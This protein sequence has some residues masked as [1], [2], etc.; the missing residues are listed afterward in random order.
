MDNMAKSKKKTPVST[1]CCCK[2]QKRGKQFSH[3]KFRR[4]EKVCLATGNYDSLFFR[5]WESVDQWDLGGDGKCYW[6]R[7]PEEEWYVRLMRK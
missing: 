1:W 6:G 2:S 3:R 7:Q 5:Q 4:H